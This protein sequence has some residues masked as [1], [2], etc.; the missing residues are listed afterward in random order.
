MECFRRLFTIFSGVMI[1]FYSTCVLAD[2]IVPYTTATIPASFFQ[3]YGIY[4]GG[5]LILGIGVVVYMI[6][7]RKK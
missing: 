3:R 4:L 7:K 2:I 5:I 1:S 6:I